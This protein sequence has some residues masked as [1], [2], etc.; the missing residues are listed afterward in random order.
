MT[1]H[2]DSNQK[3]LNTKSAGPDGF[4]HEFCQTPKEE[5]VPTF[6]KFFQKSKREG[7]LSNSP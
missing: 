3:P 4:I 7:T 1:S 2:Q 5:L 6:L